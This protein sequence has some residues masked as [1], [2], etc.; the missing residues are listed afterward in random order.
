[1]VLGSAGVAA[2][3]VVYEG[4]DG[5]GAGKHLVFLAGDHEYR[6]EES[7]PALARI[8]AKHHGFRCTVLFTVDPKTEEI[9]PGCNHM[10]GIE[11]LDTADLALVFL[12][13]QNFPDAQMKHFESYIN[14]GGPIVGFRTST[15]AF[16]IP[17]DAK[18]GKYDYRYAAAEFKNGFGRQIL[19]ETWA[20]HHGKNHVMSTRLDI[21]PAAKNHPILRGVTKPWAQAGAYWTDPTPDSQI[22]AMAQA[23]QGMTPDAKPAEGKAACPGVWV[24]SYKGRDGKTGRVFST[25]CGASEDLLDD[26]FRRMIVNACFWAA[27]M[28]DKIRSNLEIAF[29]GPYLPAT[30]RMGGYRKHVKP[31]DLAGWE[32][33]IMPQDK[34]IAPPKKRKKN[35][36]KK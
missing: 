28:E 36:N 24:R 1:M 29:V 11:A 10:P 31:S 4:S 5:P 27:G 2:P 6:S 30:Y 21:V 15:H 8:L 34:P 26:H 19:G 20:G 9:V 25:T 14:R 3:P 32:S 13:F 12:R 16:K 35:N 22:L 18:Y 7:L 17:H 23:L 33:P